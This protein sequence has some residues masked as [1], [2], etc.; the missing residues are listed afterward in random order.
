[1]LLIAAA[2]CPAQDR[3][4][5]AAW[6]RLILDTNGIGDMTVEEV[7][8]VENDRIVALDLGSKDSAEP[9]ISS[10]PGTVSRLTGLRRLCVS[11]NSLDSLPGELGELAQLRELDVAANRLARLPGSLADLSRLEEVNLSDN[12]LEQ[13]PKE[14]LSL[15]SLRVLH[16]SGNRLATLPR[17]IA[18]MDAL[19][20]LY[21]SGNSLTAVPLTLTTLPLNHIEL[22]DNS[23][24]ALPRQVGYWFKQLERYYREPQDCP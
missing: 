21:L 8:T 10:L 24:C 6:V 7:A 2:L 4:E 19:E 23:L 14:L 22:Q 5:D 17:D 3:H 15:G 13:F 1:M 20:E 18:R 12:S 16:L 11:G 9:F